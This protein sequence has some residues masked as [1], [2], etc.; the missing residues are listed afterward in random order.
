MHPKQARKRYKKLV[1]AIPHCIPEMQIAK[2]PFSPAIARW[3]RRWTD[4]FTDELFGHEMAGL[5]VVKAL[6]SR[7]ECD[8]ER[9]EPETGRIWK[10]ALIDRSGKIRKWAERNAHIRNKCLAEWY[11]YRAEILASLDGESSLLVDCHSFPSDLAPDVDVCIGFNSDASYPGDETVN[12][13]SDVFRKEGYTVA[14]NFPYANALAPFGFASR[15][16]MIE[17]NK[18]TYMDEKT[19][20]KT[21]GFVRLKG[22]ILK[23]YRS[24]LG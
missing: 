1:A 3:S 7:L 22:I 11:R 6:V 20:A 18:R 24:L 4:W 21:E 8:A 2:I 15:S 5:S 10:F 13:L 17:V 19:L 12:L 9:L 23:A 16:V 14:C